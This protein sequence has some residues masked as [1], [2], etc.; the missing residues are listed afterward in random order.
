MGI[1]SYLAET[2]KMWV[3]NDAIKVC[4]D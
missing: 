2:K 4:S 1:Q 3:R